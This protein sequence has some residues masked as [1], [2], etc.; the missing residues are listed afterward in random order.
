MNRPRFPEHIN[1]TGPSGNIFVVIGAMRAL[2][3]QH[4]IDEV[5]IDEVTAKVNATKSYTDALSVVREWF[6][7]DTIDR[8]A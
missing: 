7:V 6:A 4:E 2:L 8:T 5:T 1:A 3:R